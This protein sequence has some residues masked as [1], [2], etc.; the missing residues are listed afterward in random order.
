MTSK[1]TNVRPNELNYNNYMGKVYD[2]DIKRSIPGH[3][4]LHKIIENEVHGFLR[5]H[6]IR[7]ILEL[8][9]GTGI[10]SQKILRIVPTASLTAID[11]SEQMI[12]S[13]RKRLSQYHVKYILG[14][15]SEIKFETNFDMVVSVI[16]IHHQ[17]NDG[18]KKLFRKIFKSLKSG[19]IFIFADL[20]TYHDE[21]KASISE[22]LHYHHLVENSRDDKSLKE[23]A[24]HH[25]FLNLLAPIEDQMKWLKKSG[26]SDIQVKYEYFNTALIIAKK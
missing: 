25:K 14:D 2:D 11:F 26:F 21:N 15:Y 4:E 9:V 22:A 17:N 10:T 12:T 18:K 13:A 1:T 7:K 16:G 24:H 3:N 23:W 8:G 20:V 19:G 6:K 5:K